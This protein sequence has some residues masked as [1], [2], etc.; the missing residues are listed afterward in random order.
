MNCFNHFIM[1]LGFIS[2]ALTIFFKNQKV[3][4]KNQS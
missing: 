1:G 3:Y 4:S 2:F